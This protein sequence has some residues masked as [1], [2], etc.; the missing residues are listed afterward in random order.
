MRYELRHLVSPSFTH[1]KLELPLYKD[2]VD[3]FEDRMLYWLI[4]PAK[5]LLKVKH[6]EVAAVS[7]ATSYIEGIEIYASGEDSNGKSRR[8]FCRS[9]KKIFAGFSG[10]AYMQDAIASAL[11]DTLRCGFAH[12]AMFRSGIYFSSVRKEAFSVT[13]PKKNG[14]FD[15]KGRMES[16]VINPR[17][18]VEG[19]EGHFTEYVKELRARNPTPAKEK[20]LSAVALKWQLDKPGPFLG[21]TE[22]QFMS[23][24]QPSPSNA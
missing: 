13:W 8:F 10:P 7:L 9:F 21:M 15:R 4:V 24:A 20:F 16:A 12:D 6:G 19:I 14:D 22:E 18:F 2:I 1:E 11:Y 3:V 5:N 23:G 17:R